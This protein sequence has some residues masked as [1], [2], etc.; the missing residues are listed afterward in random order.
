MAIFYFNKDGNKNATLTIKNVLGGTVDDL[1]GNGELETNNNGSFYVTSEEGYALHE[2]SAYYIV[3]GGDKQTFDFQDAYAGHGDNRTSDVD[4]N[5][6]DEI[7]VF[8]ITVEDY[9]NDVGGDDGGDDEKGVNVAGF[10]YL[11]KVDTDILKDVAKER[12]E[13]RTEGETDVIDLGNFIINVLALPL[14]IDEEYLDENESNVILGH[15]ETD[16]KAHK[17]TQDVIVFDM[18]EIEV[19]KTYGNS[20]DYMNT[21]TTLYLPY[22]KSMTLEP[23]LV[24]DEALNIDYVVDLYTGDVTVNVKTSMNEI[25]QTDTAKLG[26][27]IPFIQYH[28][29]ETLFSDTARNGVDNGVNTAF[30]SVS[31]NVPVDLDSIFN[32]TVTDYGKIEDFNGYIEINNID[33]KTG[34]T[35][36]EKNSIVDILESGV[37]INED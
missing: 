7:E 17:I 37:I 6:D 31:R 11:Y 32:T 35:L 24:I 25:I 12:F 4:F 18:G 1:A 13:V 33:L 3:N 27:Q 34:A 36:Q 30:I 19:S 26:R 14:E 23:S 22:I 28:E 2:D 21:E 5:D 20:F 15:A 29:S 8:A 9:E 16:A 10:N